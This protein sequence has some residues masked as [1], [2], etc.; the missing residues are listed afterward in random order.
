MVGGNG[1]AP[2]VRASGWRGLDCSLIDDGGGKGKMG[3]SIKWSFGVL[4]LSRET[5]CVPGAIRERESPTGVD[6]ATFATELGILAVRVFGDMGKRARDSMVR[7][8]FNLLQPNGIV[9]YV[10]ILMVFLRKVGCLQTEL[11]ELLACSGIDSRVPMS[12]VGVGSKSAETPRKV[13]KRD[14]QLA[15]LEA[16]S[17]L[18]TRLLQ[19][20]QEGRRVD[21][22]APS[23]GELSP[24]SAVSPGPGAERGHSV[25]E[26]VRVCFSCG[27]QGHGVNRCSQVDT[28]FPFL[29]PGWSVDVRNGQYRVTRTDGTGLGSTPGNE[30]WSGRGKPPGPSAIKV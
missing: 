3:R 8:K 26:W 20:A 27:H 30:G 29:P 14:G 19:T 2:T 9:G 21:G 22:K 23:E 4:Q 15:P 16:I 24:L 11:Q 25:K 18:V 13:G 1:S 17:S 6:P 5:S 12:V 10:D 7:D 28:S